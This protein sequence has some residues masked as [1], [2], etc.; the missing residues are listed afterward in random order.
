M[1]ATKPTDAFSGHI[2]SIKTHYDK[3]LL[4]GRLT[5]YTVG[6]GTKVNFNEFCKNIMEVYAKLGKIP[7]D[8]PQAPR[9]C[10][11]FKRACTSSQEKNIPTEETNVRY[12]YN[13]RATGSSHT[14]VW[15]TIV[16][17]AVDNEGHTLNYKE[18]V[19]IN[20]D[21]T[22]EVLSFG[23]LDDDGF[24]NTSLTTDLTVKGMV[25]Y[26]KG[27]YKEQTEN[28]T[29]YYV[30]EY[31]RK[32]LER[33]M[34]AIR[35]RTSGGVYFVNEQFGEALE[36]IEGLMNEFSDA[37][38]HSL[39]LLDD[40]KQ[41]EM[42][43]NAFEQESVGDVDR[44]IGEIAEIKAEGATITQKRYDAFYKEFGELTKKVADYSDLLDTA[45]DLTGSRLEV[46]QQQM[47]KLMDNVKVDTK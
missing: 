23:P 41:R 24:G 22:T 36:A 39:P 31:V 28:V 21:R 42:L 26:I 25:E 47:F 17:E 44:L 35:V 10:D 19:L 27:Y 12:N 4:L 45:L 38:M 5:W 20:Y 30:R 18:L 34:Y 46:M 40:G 3:S 8:L 9:G 32:V 1:T 43:R 11:V 7:S 15:R 13:V 37:N 16:R 14:N 29:A 33:D 6:E 2:E